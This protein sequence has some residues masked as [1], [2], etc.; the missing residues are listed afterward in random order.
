MLD[1]A[2]GCYFLSDSR[3]QLEEADQTDMSA[4]SILELVM[5]KDMQRAVGG[6]MLCRFRDF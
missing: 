6:R 1:Y 4:E 2:E 5:G 3:M